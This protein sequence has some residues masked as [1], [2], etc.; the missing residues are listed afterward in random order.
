LTVTQSVNQTKTARQ[1]AVSQALRPSAEQSEN[2][3]TVR[4][5]DI[6]RCRWKLAGVDSNDQLCN[7]K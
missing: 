4:K 3:M 5:S 1:T 6:C 2:L 7:K